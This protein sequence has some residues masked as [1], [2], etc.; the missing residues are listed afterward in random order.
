MNVPT[1]IGA[2]LGCVYGGWFSDY[3]VQ[4]FAKRYR[5]GIS[6]AED[7]LWLLLPSAIVNP[8]GLMVF[9]IGSGQGTY[10]NGKDG[11]YTQVVRMR[12]GGVSVT[13]A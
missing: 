5:N 12:A 13:A 1:L 3:F 2:T 11:Y 7:R 10:T 9:G 8:A 6:E 4:W